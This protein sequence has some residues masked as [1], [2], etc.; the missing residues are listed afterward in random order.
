MLCYSVHVLC[1]MDVVLQYTHVAWMLCTVDGCCV[2]VYMCCVAWMLCYSIHM[3]HG[4]CVQW[5]DVVLQ[6]TC[7]VL[8]GCCVTVYTCCMDVVYSG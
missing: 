5:I 7:V 1:C 3:L 8:H 2:T 6:C 4:C